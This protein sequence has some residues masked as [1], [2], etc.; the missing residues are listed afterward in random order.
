MNFRGVELLALVLLVAACSSQAPSMIAVGRD[1]AVVTLHHALRRDGGVPTGLVQ[2]VLQLKTDCL[3]I[4]SN[5]ASFV[6]ILPAGWMLASDATLR[7]ANG[8]VAGRVGGT[9][10]FGG[11]E[12]KGQA[13]ADRHTGGR[14]S[15]ACPAQAYW[16][17]TEVLPPSP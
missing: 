12:V 14:A 15:A 17:V 5:G 1:P 6:A 8:L 2:G 13:E 11:G 4:E 3:L 10:G 9:Y 16:L 7:D